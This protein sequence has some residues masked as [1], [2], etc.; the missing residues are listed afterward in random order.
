MEN[1]TTSMTGDNKEQK[2]KTPY[3]V[4]AEDDKEMRTLLLIYLK[5]FG[6]KVKPCA[7][8][9]ELLEEISE[10]MLGDEGKIDLIISDIKMPHYTA[11][12]IMA[13][14][15]SLQG[16]PPIILITA[17]GNEDLHK[18]AIENGALTVLDKPFDFDVLLF[19]VENVLH[20]FE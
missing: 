3:I 10:S 1:V 4:V 12:E 6:Y 20:S 19:N 17:F 2:E 5:K 15:K 7:N 14:L 13:G 11:M 18:E 16:F 8:G 9:K